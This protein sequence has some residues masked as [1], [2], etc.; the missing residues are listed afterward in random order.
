MRARDR[1]KREDNCEPRDTA[2][3]ALEKT[4][5]WPH[6]SF[7]LVGPSGTVILGI[8]AASR[9]PL[10]MPYI[11]GL[12]LQAQLSPIR[13]FEYCSFLA[14]LLEVWLGA[15]HTPP[16]PGNPR[17]PRCTLSDSARQPLRFPFILHPDGTRLQH[18][19]LG[20]STEPQMPHSPTFLPVQAPSLH[21][22]LSQQCLL[23]ISLQKQQKKIRQ[24]LWLY[25]LTLSVRGG[26]YYRC[27]PFTHLNPCKS[28]E[29]AG[30][31]AC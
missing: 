8:S 1:R 19:A 9:L 26:V 27:W 4:P 25:L 17:Q 24:G 28:Q 29:E 10:T 3:S 30:L 7:S 2:A 15:P 5:A 14:G 16:A 12:H 6:S 21:P 20:F 11:P 22:C 13:T 23:S 31:C 18:R